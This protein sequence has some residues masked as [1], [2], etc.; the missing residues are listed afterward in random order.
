[1]TLSTFL[2]R[3]RV[4]AVALVTGLTLVACSSTESRYQGTPHNLPTTFELSDIYQKNTF[5]VESFPTSRWLADGRGFTTLEAGTNEGQDIVLYAATGEQ[6]E[7]MVSASELTPDGAESALTIADYQWSDDASKVLIFTNTRR[8]WRTHTLGD[9]WV[10]DRNSGELLQLGADMPEA[11]LQFAKFNPSADR[12]AFVME[13]NLYVQVLADRSVTQ[14][15]DDGSTDTINGTFDWVNEEEFY[16]RDGFRWSPDGQHIAYWQLDTSDVPMFTMI[17]NV[18]ELY[19]TLTEFPYPKVG[20]TNSAMRIG[21]M[22]SHGGETTWMQ[23]PGKPRDHY[24]VRMEWAGNSDELLIQQMNRAQ[25]TMHL[26]VAERQ[27]GNVQRLL[28][29]QSD[30]WVEQVDDIQF[31][32]NG[33]SF[34]WLSER[35]GFRQL[36]RVDRNEQGAE[37]SPLTSDEHRDYDIID[38]KQIVINADNQGWVYY[39]AAPDNPLQRV[40]MRAAIQPQADTATT[41]ERLTPADWAGTHDYQ[42]DAKG[43]FAIHS[44]ASIGQAPQ[45]RMLSLPDHEVVSE[46]E[47]NETLADTLAER[48]TSETEFFRVEARDGLQLDAYI[49]RPADLDPSKSYPLLMYVYG[50]P[51]GQTV[52]D[53]WLGHSWLWHEYLTQQGF[54]VVSVDNRGTR[55]PRGQAWRHSIYQ[56][57]GVITVRDQADALDA[58]TDRWDY[59]DSERV[60]IWGHSGGGSQTL[61]ALFRYPEKFHAG[62]ALAPVPDLRLYDTIYQERYSGL[63]PE[64]AESYEYTSAVSHAGNLQGDLLLVHGTADDNVHY[65]GSERLIDELVRA[66]KQFRFMAYPNRT[67]GISEGEGTSLHLR[68]MMTEFLQQNLLDN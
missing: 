48:I 31:F 49:M 32:N 63:L 50:E 27:Q 20:E 68:T 33:Q 66:Q 40:L 1:M 4:T 3:Q 39:V 28:T 8:S 25:N 53:N 9:Y 52:A 59:I 58:I 54:I 38:V 42:I 51:W 2:R 62:I 60:A 6:L 26:W 65:Q 18:S 15:T 41:L 11:T 13:N 22:P 43:E 12:V 44:Y 35:N 16:L 47:L 10:L 57:L 14:L 61:N 21:V 36:Y 56:Q 19:P 46:L 29:E 23:L 37:L 45:T 55:S 5:A 24:L 7:V 67:H 30:A 17:D 64:A 34:T